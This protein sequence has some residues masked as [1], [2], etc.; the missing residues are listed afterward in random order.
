MADNDKATLDEMGLDAW[1]PPPSYG[2]AF[3]SALAVS[4]ATGK[5]RVSRCPGCDGH[6]R[7]TVD[8]DTGESVAACL[9]CKR[10]VSREELE[11][12]YAR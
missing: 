3:T 10:R 9:H 6:L 7:A 8:K 11:A 1:K 5:L 2:V 12:A 4:P